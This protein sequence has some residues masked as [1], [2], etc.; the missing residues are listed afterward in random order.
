MKREIKFRI[1][2][3]S[4]NSFDMNPH[5]VWSDKNPFEL[6]KWLSKYEVNQ[7][8]GLK[9]RDKKEIYE[10]DIVKYEEHHGE[11]PEIDIGVIEY[12]EPSAC[13]FINWG[14]D[15]YQMLCEV[16]INVIGNIY[17][18]PDLI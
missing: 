4:E 14:E 13:F 18:N 10:G 3:H 16:E 17:E 6:N 9:D 1:W 5:V 2:N 7:Y 12:S 11:E 15:R 8:T